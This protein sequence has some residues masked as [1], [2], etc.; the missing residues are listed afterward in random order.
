MKL[1]LPRF[2][3]PGPRALRR[4]L[5]VGLFGGLVAAGTASGAAPS[6]ILVWGDSLSAGYG[7]DARSGW[8]YLL[9]QKLKSQ[10]PDHVVVNG[11]VSG[12]TT[13]G[14]LARLPAALERH[15]PDLLLIELG[16]NDG[17]R[18]QPLD[19]MKANLEK[20][21]ALAKA[22]GAQPVIFEMRIPS[23]Y[24][25]AF[26]ERFRKTF[27]DVASAERVPLVPFFLGAFAT[28]PQRWFQDDGIHPN[29]AA[30][31][32]ML[33]AVWPTIAPL[34]EKRPSTASRRAAAP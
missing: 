15:H 32:R 30:Q 9:E 8:V 29:A 7:L 13:A 16:G 31:P 20:M 6:T 23:N 25:P 18:G 4:W 33:E 27:A 26:T 34:I 12:E 2:C 17:L 5:T 3:R 22:A 19:A 21:T 10:A 28:E 14:G 1:R 24:G 11:S